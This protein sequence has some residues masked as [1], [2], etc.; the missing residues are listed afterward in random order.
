MPADPPTSLVSTRRFTPDDT[1]RID[2]L[3]R[4]A[5]VPVF[6]RVDLVANA[7]ERIGRDDGQRAAADDDVARISHRRGDVGDGR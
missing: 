1:V 4:D 6:E 5:F 3:T 7:R 2:A